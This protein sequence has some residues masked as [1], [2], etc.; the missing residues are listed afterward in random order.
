MPTRL[1]VT[2]RRLLVCVACAMA[3]GCASDGRG[4][5]TESRTGEAPASTPSTPVSSSNPITASTPATLAS[6]SSAIAAFAQDQPHIAWIVE[7]GRC[8]HRLRLRELSSGRTRTIDGVGCSG[9]DREGLWGDRLALASGRALWSADAHG[10]N[11]QMGIRYQTAS[12]ANPRI[13]TLTC[14]D[15]YIDESHNDIPEFPVAGQGSLLLYYS[16]WDGTDGGHQRAVRRVVAGDARR[17]FEVERPLDLAVD[18]GRIALTTLGELRRGEGCGCNFDPVWSPDGRRI[19]FL[20]SDGPRSQGD[21]D[22][23]AP[24]PAEI[25]VMNADGTDLVTLT[26]DRRARKGLDWS[27]DGSTFVYSYGAYSAETIAVADADGS[28]ARDVAKGSAPDWSPN[29]QAIVFEGANETVSIVE[30]DG[31]GFRR[32]GRGA[33]PRWSPDGQHI[34]F[35]REYPGRPGV[36]LMQSDGKGVR[37]IAGR[38]DEYPSRPAWSPDGRKIAFAGDD[39]I[40][41]VNADGSGRRALAREFGG[42]LDW[43]PDGQRLL[44]SSTR[45]DLV[46]DD[47][48]ETELY[49]IDS[50][51]GRDVRGLAFTRDEWLSTGQVRSGDGRIVA[52][53]SATGKPVAVTLSTSVVALL[54][55]LSNGSKRISAF[56]ARTGSPRGVFRVARGTTGALASDGQV[57]LF[58]VGRT[59]RSLDVRTGEV[60]VLTRTGGTP[61]GLSVSGRR[62][63]WAENSRDRGLIRAL[64]LRG[65]P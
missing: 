14:C 44:F 9:E 54:S 64:R 11:Q 28:D 43:S 25:G 58:S 2:S 37:R 60:R 51:T 20:R 57:V 65:A 17:L 39:G 10:S 40:S 33:D 24:I 53:F 55:D 1:I 52:S 32:L 26:S 49:V 31:T 8:G 6:S 5:D 12:L 29:G 18:R 21:L 59:I 56:D 3:A 41:I 35:V 22:Y 47:D 34:A 62:V 13:R 4:S 50:R 42:R 36:Y 45:D 16:H 27:S 23:E 38:S 15:L 48:A 63:A 46:P 19:A 7:G 30:P 61:I